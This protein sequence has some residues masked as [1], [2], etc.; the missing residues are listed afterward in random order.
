MSRQ[1]E[2]PNFV[3]HPLLRNRHMMTIAGGKWPRQLKFAKMPGEPRRFTV[4]PGV[5]VLGHCHWQPDRRNRLT[6]VLLHGL[7]ASS[8][9]PYI[10]GAAEKAFNLGL[11]VLRLNQRNCGGTLHLTPTL[12]NSGLSSDPLAVI[13]ELAGMDGLGPFV[14]AGWSMGGNLVLKA[15]AEL[16]ESARSLVAGVC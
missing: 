16:G 5:E 13:R 8:D 12:Y 2:Y 9:S 15:V 11:N 7:E 4:E 6:L 1:F 14:L 10:L 3:P